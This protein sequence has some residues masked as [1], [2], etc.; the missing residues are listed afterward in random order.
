MSNEDLMKPRYKVI[1]D[2]PGNYRLIG[3]IFSAV[4]DSYSVKYWCAEKDKY[5]HLFQRLEWWQER[6]LEDMPQFVKV[7][8]EECV[9]DTGLYCK[10]Y[11]WSVFD[12]KL[13]LVSGQ[14]GAEL[15]GYK[16]LYL[17]RTELNFPGQ[18]YGRLNVCNLL[19][20][21]EADYN[22]WKKENP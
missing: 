2:Y 20:A 10:V 1:A 6:N 16:P 15:E 19:P 12:H 17:A 11:K 4:G 14:F 13:P 21:T 5:P 8:R 18:V 9:K 22:A 3:E 7:T